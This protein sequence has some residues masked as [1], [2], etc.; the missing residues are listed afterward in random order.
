MSG[1]GPSLLNKVSCSRIACDRIW[2]P[3]TLGVVLVVAASLRL[4]HVG[5]GL[6][7]MPN[8][9]EKSFVAAALDVASG[10]LDPRWYKG[11]S[12]TIHTALGAL[13][14]GM[15]Q[16]DRLR[17]DPR[18]FQAWRNDG[19]NLS[20]LVIAGRGLCA[21]FDVI[22]VLLVHLMVLRLG[23]S[24]GEGLLAAFLYALS[25]Q[26]IDMCHVIREDHL[27]V[28][29]LLASSL[30]LV[31]LAEHGTVKRYAIAG[32]CIGLAGASKWPGLVM[33][34]PLITV[35]A[36]SG[37]WG[38]RIVGRREAWLI[39]SLVACMGLITVI[40]GT[41]TDEDW[42]ALTHSSLG[43]QKFS[44]GMLFVRSSLLLIG[45]TTVV[46]GLIMPLWPAWCARGADLVLDRRIVVALTSCAGAFVCVAPWALS[47]WRGLVEGIVDD[48]RSHR[49]GQQGIPGL[50]NL[51]FYLAGPMR[52]D[53]GT[54]SFLLA[55]LGLGF[56][57]RRRDFRTLVALLVPLSYLL[58]LTRGSLHWWHYAL[59][60]SPYIALLAALGVSSVIPR[61][62]SSLVRVTLLALATVLPV[63]SAYH[64]AN[65]FGLPSTNG[66]ASQWL[67]DRA[68]R[69]R[70][71]RV[72]QEVGSVDLDCRFTMWRII[73][74]SDVYPD[75]L[76]PTHL[77]YFIVNSAVY[78]P[79]LK[80]P[81]LYPTQARNY[82]DLFRRF[83]PVAS[84]A[85]GP[86]VRGPTLHIFSPLTRGPEPR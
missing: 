82:A 67:L 26:A 32:C 28:L 23:R 86:Q 42:I 84:F 15:Y 63:Q 61:R 14:R 8:F 5:H 72:L 31:G 55:L 10:R 45:W 6:P 83:R 75:G 34:A 29:F 12:C 51:W 59:P 3:M 13:Y 9:D 49:V 54:S 79:V 47:E 38:K 36:A 19:R 53:L 1:V 2:R 20:K 41:L 17:G 46:S 22:S 27:L 80:D 11:P 85:P 77:D 65:A 64:A 78:E 57:V 18:T 69:D 70:P 66:L 76:T 16:I 56:V 39:G 60:L 73:S 74:I 52:A 30:S 50:S 48:A 62:C 44:D 68:H 21:L 58:F 71:T 7:F 24:W 81:A 43:Y 4:L 37:H 40:A 33:L 25:L 35:H